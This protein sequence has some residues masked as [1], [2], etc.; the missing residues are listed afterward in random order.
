MGKQKVFYTIIGCMLCFCMFFTITACS[1][2][3][4]LTMLKWEFLFGVIGPTANVCTMARDLV[5][6]C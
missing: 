5:Q 4:K 3:K 6:K 2:E 1:G